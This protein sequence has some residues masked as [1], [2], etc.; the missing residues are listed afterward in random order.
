MTSGLAKVVERV[1]WMGVA[2]VWS[3]AFSLP[4]AAHTNHYGDLWRQ[5]PQTSV[6][7]VSWAFTTEVNGDTKRDSIKVAFNKWDFEDGAD[8]EFI[9]S[10]VDHANHSGATRIDCNP[11]PDND[12]HWDDSWGAQGASAICDSDNDGLLEAFVAIFN[13]DNQWNLGSG[14]PGT[15]EWDLRS[16]ATHEAGHVWGFTGHFDEGSSL[17]PQNSSRHTMCPGHSSVLGTDWLRT[18]ETHDSHTISNAYP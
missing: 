4:G 13:P 3:L 8:F 6:A 11:L 16:I 18:L 12:V 7:S 5:H 10:S 2:V 17:C 14:S 9:L 15:Q 1:L